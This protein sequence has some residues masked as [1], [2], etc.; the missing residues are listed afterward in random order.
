MLSNAWAC[1]ATG[2]SS[3]ITA[4]LGSTPIEKA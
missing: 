1:W 2:M 3:M 4:T